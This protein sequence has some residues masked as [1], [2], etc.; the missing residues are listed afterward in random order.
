MDTLRK[1]LE[2]DP[3]SIEAHLQMPELQMVQWQWSDAESEIRHALALNPNRVASQG[4]MANWLTMHGRTEEALVWAH[5]GR[6]LDPIEVADV[7]LA[8]LFFPGH[9]F[10]EAVQEARIAVRIRPDDPG[11]LLYLGYT[12][13]ASGQP[14]DAIPPM[15][16]AMAI[17]NRSPG[18]IGVLIR[19]YAMR[20]AAP[21]HSVSSRN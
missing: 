20:D 10:P 16:R 7:D 5:R 15:E 9:R 3:H 1:A 13:I 6:E 18:V 8:W 2:L 11:A 21:T 14:E 19:A 4:C 12:L 17:S